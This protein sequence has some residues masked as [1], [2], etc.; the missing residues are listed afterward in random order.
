MKMTDEQRLAHQRLLA[1]LPVRTVS[2]GW[3]EAPC[4]TEPV[5]GCSI[6]RRV[7]GGRE[8]RQPLHASVIADTTAK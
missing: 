2:E 1:Q 4:Q 3:D 7:R 5:A 6:A 8:H